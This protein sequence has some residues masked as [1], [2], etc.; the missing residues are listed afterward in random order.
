[1]KKITLFLCILP[2]TTLIAEKPSQPEGFQPVPPGAF[3]SFTNNNSQNLEETRRTTTV[4]VTRHPKFIN[5][6]PPSAP[7]QPYYHQPHTHYNNKKQF[8]YEKEEYVTSYYTTMK[9]IPSLFSLK[10]GLIALGALGCGY[11][12]LYIRLVQLSNKAKRTNGW[13]SFQE[14]IPPTDLNSLA[15]LALAD[16]IIE[17]IK[18]RYPLINPANL[19]P[20]LLLFNKD[21]EEELEEL[22][23]YISF[24]MWLTTYKLTQFFPNQEKLI[25]RAQ[26]KIQRL[27]ILQDSIAEWINE[28]VTRLMCNQPIPRQ[29]TLIKRTQ[30]T[31]DES[32][33]S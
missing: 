31:P 8:N 27:H 3:F 4:K 17:E 23:T 7:E 22:T 32:L 20:S 15:S 16:G 33:A 1:M 25:I 13:G 2:L 21:I 29:N 19:M 9:N 18:L 26:Q 30:S 28:H 6:Q 10:S 24:C 11:A 12:L 5:N 14:H